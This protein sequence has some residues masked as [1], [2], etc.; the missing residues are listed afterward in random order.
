MRAVVE[1][2]S[3][4]FVFEKTKELFWFFFLL[5]TCA[6]RTTLYVAGFAPRT[7]ARDLGYEFER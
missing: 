3:Y 5:P 6:M 7:R 4:N 1:N 2:F